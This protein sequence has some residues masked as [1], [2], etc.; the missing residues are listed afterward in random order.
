MNI[1]LKGYLIDEDSGEIEITGKV[2]GDK[3]VHLHLKELFN[4]NSEVFKVFLMS[5]GMQLTDMGDAEIVKEFS[6][7]IIKDIERI[8]NTQNN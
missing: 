2:E 5:V 1:E 4:R 3:N 7:S 6:E 8:N